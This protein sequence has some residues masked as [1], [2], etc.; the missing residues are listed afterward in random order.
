[1]GKVNLITK[2]KA[3]SIAKEYLSMDKVKAVYITRDGQTFLAGSVAYARLHERTH[4]L[5]PSWY[6]ASKELKSTKESTELDIDVDEDTGNSSGINLATMNKAA[7]IEVANDL[8]EI[9]KAEKT[10]W[11]SLN[12][13]N[14]RNYLK[15]KI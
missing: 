12:M 13:E 11:S 5:E 7:L 6:Y 1:M 15:E 9:G 3:D 8:T 14:L 10:E 4:K 2:E